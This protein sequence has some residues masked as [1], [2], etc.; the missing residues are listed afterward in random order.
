MTSRTGTYAGAL[1]RLGAYLIDFGIATALLAA[2]TASL[3]VVIGVITGDRVE[4]DVSTVFG[5][6]ATAVFN[7]LYF[8]VCWA[9]AAKTPGMALVGLRVTRRDGAPLGSRHAAIRALVFPFSF[10]LG[11]GLIGVVVGREHRAL[12]DV[13]ADTVVLYD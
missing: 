12:H 5:I 2:I 3:A 11:L 9:L 13:A 8:F 7:F 1:T 10:I 4:I 6:S